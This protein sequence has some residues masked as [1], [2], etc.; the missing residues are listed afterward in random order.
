MMVNYQLFV[1]IARPRQRPSTYTG[2]QDRDDQRL[3]TGCQDLL[4]IDNGSKLVN[5]SLH[6]LDTAQESIVV[7]ANPS[8]Q[9]V[10][11]TYLITPVS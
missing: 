5:P 2:G 8:L 6:A 7:N 4:T 9:L 3:G 11:V 10:H 1:L